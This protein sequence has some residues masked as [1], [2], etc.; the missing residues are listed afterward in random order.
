[1]SRFRQRFRT[2]VAL[3][4]T[5]DSHDANRQAAMAERIEKREALDRDVAAFDAMVAARPLRPPGK[6]A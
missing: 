5:R 4:Q 2:T 3:G 1:M 6:V